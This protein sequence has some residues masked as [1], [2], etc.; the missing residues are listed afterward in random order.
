MPQSNF[1]EPADPFAAPGPVTV[2]QGED[3]A[4]QVRMWPVPDAP[5]PDT[6]TTYR[7][8]HPDEWLRLAPVF[9]AYGSTLP[10]PQ[11]ASIAVAEREGEIIG[12]LTLQ[13]MLHVEPSWLADGLAPDEYVQRMLGVL[14]SALRT[15]P[16]AEQG[17]NLFVFS[18]SRETG[19]LAKRNGFTHLPQHVW[20]KLITR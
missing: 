7:I 17:I 9:A 14:E 20:G 10:S 11:H 12:F 2:V 18:P 13:P 19:E 6:S 5:A 8:L 1:A 16:D 15:T 4:D 3:R